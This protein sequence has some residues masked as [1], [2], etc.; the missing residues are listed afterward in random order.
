MIFGQALILGA[1][2]GVTE[3]LPIS[4]TGH[5]I[6]ADAIFKIVPSEFVKSFNIAIQLGAILAALALYARRLWVDR[7]LAQKTLVA[8]V[9]TAVVGLIFYQLVKTYLLGNALVVIIALVLGGLA[10]IWFERW[11]TRR[12]PDE[13]RRDLS[14]L[15]Y[16][17]AFFIGLCQSVALVPGV[18]R[19][20]ATIV[21][22]LALGLTRSAVVEFSFL[23]AIPTMLAATALDLSR[24]GGSFSGAEW[25]QLAV[26]FVV[27][28]VLALIAIRWLLAFVR[29]HNFTAFGI[30][31]IILAL[32]A[33]T[34]LVV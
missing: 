3:F 18:S 28:F 21:G 2:E 17:Q 9:P 16:R 34:I 22:G 7:T 24:V 23:L 32:L 26:G 20:A 27:S 8:F 25:Q 33:L 19:S 29:R 4:S 31:R 14:D 6:L 15:S 12:T 10:L 11:L 13:G 5:L 1:V 30:Y